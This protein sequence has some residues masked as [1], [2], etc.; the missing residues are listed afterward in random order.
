MAGQC[1]GTMG[2]GMSGY[3]F[4]S[5]NPDEMRNSLPSAEELERRLAQGF[6]THS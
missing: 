2:K 4:M 5:L 1:P 6:M 3:T